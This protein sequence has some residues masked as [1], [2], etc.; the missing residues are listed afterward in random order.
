MRD[1]RVLDET[2]VHLDDP[3][4]RKMIRGNPSPKLLAAWIDKGVPAR[5]ESGGRVHL[6]FAWIGGRRVTSVEAVLRFDQ[7]VNGID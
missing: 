5:Y 4:Q 6:D 3:D 7:A 2:I 1:M